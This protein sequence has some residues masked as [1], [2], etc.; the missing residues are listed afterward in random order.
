MSTTLP[1]L[2]QLAT[3][4][5]WAANYQI[6]AD[7]GIET[8]LATARPNVVPELSPLPTLPSLQQ[9]NTSVLQQIENQIGGGV[10]GSASSGA[11]PAV[12]V[13]P[14][15]GVPSVTN[16]SFSSNI[17]SILVGLILIFGAVLSFSFVRDTA[18]SAAKGL[19]TA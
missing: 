14:S 5:D 12:N 19:A 8:P 10:T 16:A 1:S 6:P 7:S 17:A 13:D 2:K 11:M 15:T 18:V 9:Q 4:Q 3:P